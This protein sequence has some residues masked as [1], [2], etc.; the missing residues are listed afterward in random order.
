MDDQRTVL[1]AALLLPLIVAR[2]V[3]A[4]ITPTGP[5]I[6]V[7]SS[8]LDQRTPSV[9]S[10]SSGS[11]RVAVWARRSSTT[12]W[13]IFGRLYDHLGNARSSE[14]AIAATS[15]CERKPVVAADALGDF[16]VAWQVDQA[17]GSSQTDVLFRRYD[18]N[19]AALS[20]ATTAH[21]I[22]DGRQE[23]PAV[24]RAPD[25]RFAVAWQS[26]AQDGAGWSVY[27]R[28]YTAAGSATFP[29]EIRANA[30]ADG[31][32]HSPTIAFVAFPAQSNSGFRVAW[33]TNGQ[34]LGRSFNASAGSLESAD[35][36]L[37][38]ST[39]DWLSEPRLAADLSGNLLVAAEG[40]NKAGGVPQQV[41]F[42]RW[43]GSFP[44]SSWIWTGLDQPTAGQAGAA[45]ATRADGDFAIAW[46][47]EGDGSFNGIVGRSYSN[48]EIPGGPS[49]IVNLTVAGS[50][51]NPALAGNA[52]GGLFV[53]WESS[54]GPAQP[55]SIMARQLIID[56]HRFYTVPACRIL[57]TR[58]P[59]GP[60]GGPAIAA[61]GTRVFYVLPICGVPAT[62]RALALNVTVV[63]GT[64]DGS[65]TIEPGD[66]R[67]TGT[68]VV[69][70]RGGVVRANSAIRNVA[71]SGDGSLAVSSASAQPVN[72]IL[73]VTGYFE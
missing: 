30:A 13:D 27:F 46:D 41:G 38:T 11:Y 1:F 35:L 42:R 5:E 16:V 39:S 61:G 10:D 34:V 73:D 24:A 37:A 57:D 56:P 17:P 22:L 63:P 2:P 3:G 14:F 69:N 28:T 15:A 70:F 49:S 33:E 52:G 9:A 19:G 71:L 67:P 4:A 18:R 6:T 45:V 55:A 50:Q 8:G 72:V 68:S 29:S 25:G 66:S 54:N 48:Q 36:V 65:V 59:N 12:G 53:A 47:A 62:A 44:L 31:S 32:Q 7:S 21:T 20:L 58:N 64:A 60:L 23:R 40:T 43:R 51:S 26:L